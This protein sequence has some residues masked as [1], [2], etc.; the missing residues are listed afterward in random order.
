MPWP[1]LSV[2]ESYQRYHR[3]VFYMNK[4]GPENETVCLEYTA[5]QRINVAIW[6]KSASVLQNRINREDLSINLAIPL[7]PRVLC[8][9]IGSL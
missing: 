1:G 9:Q 3:T 6:W 4:W 2:T 8:D 5:S 7:K